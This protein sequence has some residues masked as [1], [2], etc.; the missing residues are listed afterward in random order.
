M[1][2][3]ELELPLFRCAKD[4]P[5]VEGL[6]QMLRRHG[7]WLTA[8]ELLTLI[9]LE[10]TDSNR[11]LVRAWAEAAQDELITGQQG[12]RHIECATSEE[13]HHFCSWMDSQGNK[14]KLRAAR[15]RARAHKLVG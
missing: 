13:I 7:S 8:K 1:I 12:Y 14:M 15:T 4:D 5:H 2:N 9:S 6:V 10:D 11:R 3:A